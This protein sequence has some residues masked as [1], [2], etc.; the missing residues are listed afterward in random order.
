MTKLKVRVDNHNP[1]NTVLWS[2]YTF[3]FAFTIGTDPMWSVS[4]SPTITNANLTAG[5]FHHCFSCTRGC[6]GGGLNSSCHI[7]WRRGYALH[8]SPV[9]FRATRRDK[10]LCIHTHCQFGAASPTDY[11]PRAHTDIRDNIQ[12]PHGSRNQSS[13][14][15][16]LMRQRQQLHNLSTCSVL[17]K[18]KS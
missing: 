2:R 5:P 9:Y 13:D 17:H 6:K 18:K 3:F 15:L 10:R 7:G 14:L 12:T 4:V 8:L 1:V 11:L 16:A